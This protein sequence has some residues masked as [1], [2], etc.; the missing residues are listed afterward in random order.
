MFLPSP[1]FFCTCLNL[2]LERAGRVQMARVVNR[3]EP[4]VRKWHRDNS[5]PPEAVDKWIDYLGTIGDGKVKTE[6]EVIMEEPFRA[7]TDVYKWKMLCQGILA[8]EDAFLPN[9]F[10]TILFHSGQWLDA[11]SSIRKLEEN[12]RLDAFK[13]QL[14]SFGGPRLNL[15]AHLQVQVADSCNWESLR[16]AIAWLLVENFIYILPES[17]RGQFAPLVIASRNDFREPL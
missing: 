15:P 9:T 12:K 3:G 1:E 7:T 5:F 2:N 17:V 4:C 11:M 10:G 16:P 13:N 6:I 8:N 14:L